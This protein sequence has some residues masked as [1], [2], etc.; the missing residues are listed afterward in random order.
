MKTMWQK[1]FHGQIQ[2]MK[3][4]LERGEMIYKG[5]RENPGYKRFKQETM[6]VHYDAIDVFWTLMQEHGMVEKCECG[7]MARRWTDCKACGGSG[8]KVLAGH[9]LSDEIRSG[10]LDPA[11]WPAKQSEEEEIPD[12]VVTKAE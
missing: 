12:G 3:D 5:D 9:G 10:T 1:V 11:A 6:R 4:M 2:L 8:F 7:A